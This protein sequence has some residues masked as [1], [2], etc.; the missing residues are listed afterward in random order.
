MME[1]YK[2]QGGVFVALAPSRAPG[3]VKPKGW[4]W[5]PDGRCVSPSRVIRSAKAARRVALG[6]VH[7]I[8][9]RDRE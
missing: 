6:E 1:G 3:R 9:W 7:P 4:A 5:L 2:V 8:V